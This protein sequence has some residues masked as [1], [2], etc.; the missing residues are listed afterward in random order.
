MQD[1]CI[2]QDNAKQMYLVWYEWGAKGHLISKA[3]YKLFIGAKKPTKYFCISVL[4]SKNG[5]INKMWD[6]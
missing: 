4:V 6:K 1:L 3:I 5:Q 2:N